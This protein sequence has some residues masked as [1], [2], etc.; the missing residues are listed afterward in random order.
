MNQPIISG[1]QQV[2][3]GV[4][5]V[6]EAWA[7]YRKAFGMDLP[8]FDEAAE[9]ALMLP[10]TGGEARSRHAVLAYNLQGG[11][12]MEIWQYTSR[13]PQPPDFEVQL[14]DLGIFV[15]KIKCRDVMKAHAWYTQQ[16]YDMLGELGYDPLGNPHFFVKDPY[17]N[18]FQI[19]KSD[20]WFRTGEHLTGGPW[21]C[22]IG[23][24]DIEQARELYTGILGYDQVVYEREGVF[25]DFAALPG[26][27]MRCRRVMLRHSQP[28]KG[29]FS[30][31]FGQSQIELVSVQG[32][33]PRKI[34]E[35]RLWGDLGFIHLCFDI[36]GM[37]AMRSLCESKGFP[38]TVDS[39]ESFDMGEAAGHFS[40]IEDPDGTLIEFVET[41]KVPIIKKLGWYLNMKKRD[42]EKP[43][44]NWMLNALRF[45]R[46]K[47]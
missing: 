25:A 39:S 33:I 30:R 43:L 18:I 22:M 42:P 27:E 15:C 26:G 35:G 37:D 34:F 12:G 7:W 31:L 9:A 23:V 45:S 38:F 24:S 32:R 20:N 47:D 10:Y 41:H 21:G 16:G 1:I 40:Y 6:Y 46:V 44:P 29:S 19:E 8:I 17:G 14:G 28:R 11:G 36:A 13:T 3:I 2:G 5:D 4:P